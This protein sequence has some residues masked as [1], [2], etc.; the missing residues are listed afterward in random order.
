M[1]GA[2]VV[3]VIAAGACGL[4]GALTALLAARRGWLRVAVAAL[5]AVALATI[6]FLPVSGSVHVPYVPHLPGP[7]LGRLQP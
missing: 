5:A 6:V 7:G 4:A 3:V 1:P 2:T